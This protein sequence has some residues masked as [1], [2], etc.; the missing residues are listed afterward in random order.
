[1]RSS[2]SIRAYGI[3]SYRACSGPKREPLVVGSQL[4][5]LTRSRPGAYVRMDAIKWLSHLRRR[6]AQANPGVTQFYT[7]VVAL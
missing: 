1:M 7:N 4:R 3:G 5:R 6:E 2:I